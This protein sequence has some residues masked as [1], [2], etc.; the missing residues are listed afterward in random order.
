MAP[1]ST[2]LTVSL[3]ATC[4]GGQ[5]CDFARTT[6][7]LA[8][9]YRVHQNPKIMSMAIDTNIYFGVYCKRHE[10]EAAL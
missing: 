10:F 2:Q 9:A 4:C 6:P 8:T 5:I 7:A 1:A 3:G